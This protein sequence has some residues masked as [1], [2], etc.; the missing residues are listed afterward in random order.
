MSAEDPGSFTMSG[1]CVP[2]TSASQGVCIQSNGGPGANFPGVETVTLTE[3]DYSSAWIAVPVTEG[4]DLLTSETGK[5]TASGASAKPTLTSGGPSNTATP[6]ANASGTGAAPQES[7]AA[8][9]IGAG[10]LFA[11]LGAV[12][13]V[14]AFF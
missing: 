2:N 7:G 1:S 13:A 10:G 6:E 14:A 8:V 12:G 5:P 3:T 4:A 9:R 11:G